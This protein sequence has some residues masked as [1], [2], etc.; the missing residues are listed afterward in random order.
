[1]MGRLFTILLVTT[2][3]YKHIQDDTDD[4]NNDGSNIINFS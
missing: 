1:M 3:I 2:T 4:I